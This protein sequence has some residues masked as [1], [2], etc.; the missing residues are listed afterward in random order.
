MVNPGIVAMIMQLRRAVPIV[1]G[2]APKDRSSVRGDESGNSNSSWISAPGCPL[3]LRGPVDRPFDRMGCNFAGV[4]ALEH[5]TAVAGKF[6][7]K[8]AIS[9]GAS[10]F[11]YSELLTKVLGLGQVIATTVPDGQAVGLLLGNSVWHPIATLACM[12]AGRPLVPLNPR[13][14]A[15]R[16]ADIV[17]SARISVLICQG[18]GDPSDWMEQ[19]GV[20]RID[21]TRIDGS[22][23]RMSSLAPVHVDAPAMVLYTSGSTGR[24]KGV[25]NSQRSLLQRVQQYV[26]ACHIGADDVFMPLS[27]PTTI[28]GC[29]ETLSALLSGATLY[30]ADVEAI[31]LRST[32]RQIR[33]QRITITYCV[34][35]LLRA[36]IA[37]GESDDFASLRVIRIGGEKVLWT[38]IALIRSTMKPT[39][40]IQLGY[41]STETTGAQWFLPLDRQEQG[42]NVPTGYML[43]GLSYA[44][45]DDDGAPVPA[46]QTGELVIKSNY[47][48]LGYWENGQLVPWPSA[49]DD[50]RCRIFPTGDLVVVDSR[51]LMQVVGRKGRQLKINGRRVEPA[52]LEVVVRKIPCVGDAVVIIS[53]ANELVVFATP[54]ADATA[55]FTKDIREVV[56]RSLPT[57]LH[58]SRVHQ[59]AE[60]P[61][62]PAGKIDVAKLQALDLENRDSR[63]L[64]Q[65]PK[66]SEMSQAREALEQVWPRI[67]G[68]VEVSGRWDEA[69]G[70]SLKLLRC[71]ME[72]EDL[73]GRELRLEAFTVDMSVPDMIQ[74]IAT[75]SVSDRPARD[76]ERSPALVLLPG[77]M[78]YGPSLAA[79]GVE[80][81][82]VAHVIPIRYPDLASVLAGQ[83][84]IDVMADSALDQINAA[85]PRGEIRLLGYSLGGGVAFEVATR[86][87]AAGRSV[88]FFGIL[89]TSIESSGSRNYAETFSRTLQRIRSHRTTVYR[90]LCRAVAKC[91]VRL[92]WEVGFCRFL[93]APVSRK[94]AT[95]RFMLRLELEEILRMEAFRRWVTHPKRRLPI[96]G[97]IF[98]CNRRGTP[99]LGWDSVFAKVGVIPIA[100]GHLD[101]VIEPHLAVNGPVIKQTIASSYSRP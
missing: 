60:I 48:L 87:I 88:E 12:A 21:I 1:F 34:P 6:P 100:G 50:E 101:L 15:Q 70:D 54:G 9:D 67:L 62:L 41:S 82:K 20:Q 71:V 28:A 39:C 52:E 85:H 98:R 99:A 68:N 4:A 19:Q 72:L 73:L 38:D 8:I 55:A 51:G 64:P 44:V 57:A 90:M 79:F 81:G 56:R 16:H 96:T 25:V 30:I 46:G 83:G 78:G 61:R 31:G 66:T 43:P 27:G 95:T 11:S 69:G 26:D 89:D 24:P 29:R 35:A 91:V 86:L 53:E 58:P 22:S 36:L 65:V 80:L 17:T 74:V 7:D 37:A 47:V 5:L 13:D 63:A 42:P 75:G 97:T 77:S 10:E 2:S 18:P 94:F 23:V 33:S 92:H 76:E 32:L 3:D 49:A 45:V 84:S 93:D 40:L 59:I 14:P